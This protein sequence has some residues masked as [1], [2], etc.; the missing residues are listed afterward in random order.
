M[1]FALPELALQQ[2]YRSYDVHPDGKRFLMLRTGGGAV[3]SLSV[4]V[5]WRRQF[6][7]EGGRSK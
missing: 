7:R 5:N 3:T 1:L 6:E 4:I 2:Y